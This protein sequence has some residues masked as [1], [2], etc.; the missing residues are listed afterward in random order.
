MKKRFGIII[1]LTLLFAVLFA[2]SACAARGNTVVYIKDGGTGDG[3]SPENATSSLTS[4]HKYLD[5]YEDC[6]V[7]VCGPYTQSVSWVWSGGDYSGSVTFTSVYGG[8]DYRESA[9]AVYKFKPARFYCYGET[10]FEHMNFE[11]LG[12][13]LLVIGQHNPVTVGE[14]VTMTGNEM[15]GGSIA[16]AFCILGGYQQGDSTPANEG[17]RDTNITVLSGSKLYIVPFSRSVNVTHTGTANVK[18]GGNADVKVLHLSAAGPAGV[19]VG[20]VKV[21]ITDRAHVGVVY[22]VTSDTSINSVELTW[23]AGT[24]DD[25]QWRCEYST[26]PK[27]TI[28]EKTVL[29]ATPMAKEN[30]N[31]STLAANFDIVNSI[32][33][34]ESLIKDRLTNQTVIYVKDGGDGDGS[35]PDK[36]LPTLTEAFG[37]LDLTKE[38]T[39]V[40]CG[41]FTQPG[42]FNY[43]SDYSGKVT[44]TSVYGGVDYRKQGAAYNFGS[45][46]FICRGATAFESIDFVSSGSY[47]LMVGQHNPVTLGEGVTV[48]GENLT[49]T[50]IAKSFT[51]LGGYQRNVNDPPVSCDRDTSITVLSGSKLYIVA[52]SRETLG[53][54][55]G[56][57]NIKIGGNASVGVLHGSAAYPDGIA[58]GDVKIEICDNA[59]IDNFYGCT[60]KTTASSY[61]FTIRGGTV[62]SFNWNC[63]ATP[64]ASLTVTNGTILRAS[65]E[66]KATDAYKALLPHF[67][68]IAEIGE[69]TSFD[70]KLKSP[71]VK[72]D[73]AA[74]RGL[75]VL[76]LGRGYD[77]TGTNFGLGDNLTR[78][79]TV[80]QVIRFLGVEKEVTSGS[81][82][83]PFDDIPAWANNYVGYAYANGI[84]SGRSATKFDPDGVVDEMQFLTFM[85]RAVGYSDKDGDFVWNDPFALAY[86]SG[87]TKSASQSRSFNRGDAFRIS[88]RTLFANAK[89]GAKV[90]EVLCDKG[91]FTMEALSAAMAEAESAV[92]PKESTTL[93]VEKGFYVL[94]EKEYESKT[95]AGFMAQ[96]AGF[97]SGYEF[98]RNA[99]GTPRVAMP[100]DWFEFLNGPYAEPNSKNKHEDKL[101]KNEE[102]GLWEAWN[103]D[104]YSIDILN[105]YI[106]KEM[107]AEYGR[108]ASKVI[109]DCWVK[110]DVY[111][112]GGGHRRQGAFGLM[113]RYGYLTEHVGS[114][115]YGSLYNVNGE[116][117]IAN[118]TLALSAAAMPSL[119]VNQAELFGKATSDRD[120]VR[121]LKYFTAIISMAYI[122]SDIPT[123]MREAQGVLPEGCWQNEVIDK[124]FELYEE[125][126]DDWR[127]AAVTAEKL[128]R[129]KHY[130]LDNYNGESSINCSFILIGLLYGEGDFYETCKII[131]LAGHGGDSTTPVGLTAVAVACGWEGIDEL[132]REQINEKLWQDGRGVIVNRAAEGT[133]EAVWMF[134][135]GL[136]ERIAMADILAMYKQNFESNLKANGGRIENGNYYIPVTALG[137]VDTVLVDEFEG[138]SFSGY[139]ISGNAEL[140]S[141]TYSGEGG[142]KLIGGD[143]ESS[144]TKTVTGLTVG[145]S[146]RISA[147][148]S[149]AAEATASL[150]VKCG[151]KESLVTVHNE[152]I[153]AKRE[154]V[155]TAEADTAEICFSI[156]AGTAAQKFA[157]MDELWVLRVAEKSVGTAE[158]AEKAVS[159]AYTALD[160]KV[161][162]NGTEESFL[163][164]TFENRDKDIVNATVKIN[165]EG[166]AGVPFY[167]TGTG[168]RGVVYIPVIAKDKS[169][170]FT[171][172][173]DTGEKTLYIYDAA[174][175][176]VSERM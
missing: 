6:T 143:K 1:V 20:D 43:H 120:P 131:S 166:Y 56:T 8:V 28:A 42:D 18:I 113:K 31:Y 51:I 118:E 108:V 19:S 125:N 57:A 92:A 172:S 111:D 81:F 159:N 139:K 10:K 29:N 140:T 87:L 164:L 110:Y 129:Q 144:V 119:A 52:F 82:T 23:K 45:V 17:H 39:V 63:P 174:L 93:K 151:G 136:P 122:E 38:V 152:V 146:Y 104:D 53:E 79:Q 75:F 176:S 48:T 46:R 5:L 34:D 14:G 173:L 88:W 130:D 78:V 60:Q 25:F 86:N 61:D 106:L 3:S 7:V 26:D 165:G 90:Y 69:D 168:G 54:Y 94:S 100:D 84:T 107:Y 95:F 16:K 85:L 37:S 112:M 161:N 47:M 103:D 22:G 98:A 40:I 163:K 70:K 156:A 9:G 2:L 162:A 62:K 138:G 72:S 77:T 83:H 153:Y 137:K 36:A 124:V 24:I 160:I 71:A 4:A 142:V 32:A 149:T 58:V 127:L 121:W 114:K 117:Y 170:A 148:I 66:V 145:E 134:A 50:S 80:V 68:K 169:T 15:T 11:A 171:V 102:T 115:E 154:L 157:T 105:Q 158:I 67:D 35:S 101:L 96:L 141:V 150:S 30:S 91:V 128:C 44:F 33:D 147:F 59:V 73:Y 65:E 55:T 89:G 135:N 167:K 27:I 12:T 21:E 99:D 76:G 132:T 97:F 133:S 123:L 175:V 41:P 49:G 74:A 116:P 64:A 13:N 126:P 109:S 155:F